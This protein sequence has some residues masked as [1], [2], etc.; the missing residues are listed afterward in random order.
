MRTDIDPCDLDL[1]VLMKPQALGVC[2]L[3]MPVELG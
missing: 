3:L 2:P 1:D